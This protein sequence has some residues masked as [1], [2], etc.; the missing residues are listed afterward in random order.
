MS[1]LQS[2]KVWDRTT[3]VF[4]WINAIC[5]F[6]MV[7][8]G[9]SILNRSA[10][11]VSDQ[12][13][14]LL[15]SL[16]VSVGYVLVL[17]LLW[18]LIWTFIGSRYARWGAILPGGKG[19]MASLKS[20]LSALSTG[21]RQQYLGHNPIGK[22]SVTLLLT[23]LTVQATTG[24]VLAGTDIYCPPLGGWITEWI[25]APGVDPANVVPYLPETYDAA[26]YQEMRN[27]RAPFVLVHETNFF[28]LATLA[29]IHIIAVVITEIREGGGLISAMFTG[30]KVLDTSP[31]DGSDQDQI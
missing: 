15:K 8:L 26:A 30:R 17:N 10:F 12:G 1:E 27:F 7:V 14:V 11:D 16:H 9:V 21:R 13:T 28:I 19:Y 24:L 25:A 22:I 5:F 23:L 20:Y 2:Y 31:A 3:R 6:L 18:R 4:H 29:V